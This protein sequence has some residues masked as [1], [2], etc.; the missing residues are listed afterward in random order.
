MGRLPASGLRPGRS[1]GTQV[2][3]TGA[4]GNSCT[5][6]AEG[7]PF[8]RA[9]SQRKPCHTSRNLCHSIQWLKNEGGSPKGSCGGSK[10]GSAGGVLGPNICCA[11]VFLPKL[12]PWSWDTNIQML[13]WPLASRQMY[14]HLGKGDPSCRLVAA[15][16]NR[17]KPQPR[18][19]HSSQSAGERSP[20]ALRKD[21][22][23]HS[24]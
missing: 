14:L 6:C 23:V 12:C 3:V 7:P 1:A 20:Q 24:R 2:A 11:P 21:Q 19:Y 22:P 10:S 15:K 17:Q 5:S 16:A 8:H 18:Q 13:V 4:E 9:F